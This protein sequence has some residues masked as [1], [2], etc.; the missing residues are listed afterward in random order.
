M[1]NI[2]LCV[3]IHIPV[4]LRNYKV[5]DI[6]RKDNYFDDLAV[7]YH[8]NRIY[9][10][11][12]AP[13]FETIK[14]LFSETE[15]RFKVAVSISGITLKLLQ[16]YVPQAIKDLSDLAKN[17]CIEFLSEPWSHSIVAF[18]DPGTLA[19]QTHLHDE[20]IRSMFGKTPDIFII[21]SPVCP[22]KIWRTIPENG[23]KGIFMYSNH[24]DKSSIKSNDKNET[25]PLYKGV[26]LINY[27]LSQTLQDMDSNPDKQI[28]IYFAFLISRKFINHTPSAEP[29]IL[30]Y[31]PAILRSP[32]IQNRAVAWEA[33]MNLLLF[34]PDVHFSFP[35][36][37]MEPANHFFTPNDV[38][39][40][41]V[42]PQFKLPTNLWLKN[43]LQKEALTEQI[44]I[45]KRMKDCN[46]ISLIED[47]NL[48][49]DMDH[50]YYMDSL[51]FSTEY[52]ENNFNPYASP[53]LAFINYMNVL[54]D[55]AGRIDKKPLL[56]KQILKPVIETAI[57]T[58]TYKK[59]NISSVNAINK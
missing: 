31:N 47:W 39:D 29:H 23:K 21:H 41:K 8:A 9:S 54:D 5:F 18:T 33:I 42:D 17:G 55:F 2:C 1:T 44:S 10:D 58:S 49:Q 53:Y 13:F 50:L 28:R 19:R 43:D 38:P 25:Q 56:A 3:Q 4:I 15:G 26:F 52:G 57:P 16:N 7:D 51:F 6:N 11:N 40:K 35:S 37:M 12:L 48:L 20:V 36:E 24:L 34:D 30:V 59:K 22:E 46:R 45:N 14:K 32:F 27:A